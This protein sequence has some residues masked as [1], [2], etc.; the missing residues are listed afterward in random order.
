MYDEGTLRFLWRS[1]AAGS[2]E[3]ARSSRRRVLGALSTCEARPYRQNHTRAANAA[4]VIGSLIGGR[5][6]AERRA[7][8][9][10]RR[11]W[12]TARPAAVFC[13]GLGDRRWRSPS[14]TAAGNSWPQGSLQMC[15]HS[16]GFWHRPS[17]T[18]PL[19][20]LGKG[21]ALPILWSFPR[22]RE[23]SASATVSI[24][25]AGA[26][27]SG[28]PRHDPIETVAEGWLWRVCALAF[29]AG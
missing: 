5:A 26:E 11:C 1:K 7:A 28:R 18:A 14:P 9:S 2:G 23:G 13:L 22:A 21:A 27:L 10:G 29:P 17:A 24:G 16:V 19:N 20:L 4:W 6:G 12:P 8:I 15:S 3:A 25:G